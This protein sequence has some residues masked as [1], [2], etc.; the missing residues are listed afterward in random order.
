MLHK[1]VDIQRA[2]KSLAQSRDQFVPFVQ[3]L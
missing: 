2:P 3:L 1:T